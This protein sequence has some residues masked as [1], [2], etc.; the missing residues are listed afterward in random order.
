LFF[1]ILCR[2]SARGAMDTMTAT[3]FARLH[4]RMPASCEGCTE[5]PGYP[6]PQ[7]PPPLQAD[8]VAPQCGAIFWASVWPP[9]PGTAQDNASTLV[10]SL[11]FCFETQSAFCL[12]HSI[13][14]FVRFECTIHTILDMNSLLRFRRMMHQLFSPVSFVCSSSFC[15]EEKHREI[16]RA[17]ERERR[18]REKER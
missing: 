8:R 15:L 13:T 17:R 16:E 12:E 7:P 18:E 11:S 5:C 9:Q 2:R 3:C 10:L 14:V 4:S 6:A 1:Q